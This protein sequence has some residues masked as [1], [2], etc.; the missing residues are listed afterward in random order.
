VTTHINAGGIKLRYVVDGNK[1]GPPLV[2]LN[3]IATDIDM[4]SPQL[5]G[6]TQRLLVIRFDARG[7]GLSD[8]PPPPYSVD[9]LAGDAMALLDALALEQVHLCGI[10][11]GGLV[12]LWMTAHHPERVK[13]AVVVSTAPRIGTPEAWDERATR[14]RRGGMHAIVDLQMS[15]FFSRGSQVADGAEF[16]RIR[17]AVLAT[18]LDGY[19][20]ACGALR[21]ADLSSVVPSITVPCLIMAGNLDEATPPGQAQQLHAGIRGSEFVVIDGGHLCNV[22]NPAAFNE[23]VL[24]FIAEN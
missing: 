15:R 3:S 12:A 11:L 8:A 24:G 17:Q 16:D 2:L 4:W 1:D 18:P 20:G 13:R 7:H 19:I 6:F 23:A 21:N 14:A 9:D 10:S 22:E 5:A